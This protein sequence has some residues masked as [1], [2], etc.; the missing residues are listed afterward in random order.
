[1]FVID[2]LRFPYEIQPLI[3]DAAS[4]EGSNDNMRRTSSLADLTD[5]KTGIFSLW[6]RKNGG[7]GG[8]RF[9]LINGD[10]A[11]SADKVNLQFD[12]AN[13]L[14]LTLRRNSSYQI[15]WQ[16]RAGSYTAGPAWHHFLAAW[17]LNDSAKCKIYVDGADVTDSVSGPV[18]S[19]SI[20]YSSATW[21][22]GS[23]TTATLQNYNGDLAEMYFAPNQW[24][25]IT[26][27]SVRNLFRTPAGKPADLGSNGSVPTGSVPT[28]YF[29]LDDGEAPNN[30]AIN[31]TGKGDFT[32]GGGLATAA[33]SPSD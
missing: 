10:P 20:G 9:L 24:L 13:R 23:S 25:D 22:V 21:Y 18:A 2:P 11:A 14:V 32:V 33:T 3:C 28:I 6:F 17:D 29:H 4:F 16:C 8:Q 30:F 15:A 12:S 1:M 19:Y 7:D 5:G 31:R 27:A 26:Q